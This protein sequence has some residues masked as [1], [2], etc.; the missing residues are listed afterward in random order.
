MSLPFSTDQLELADTVRRF[1][2]ERITTEYLRK[3]A[4]GSS[5]AIL[6]N[7]LC[8]LG[9]LTSFVPE[10]LGGVGFGFR[11]LGLLAIE[12]GRALLP[13][14]ILDMAFSNYLI[15]RAS[16]IDKSELKS[17]SKN[18]LEGLDRVVFA[19]A[20]TVSEAGLTHDKISANLRVLFGGGTAR[21]ALIS[22]ENKSYL[23][24]IKSA[25][26]AS[27]NLVDSTV[28]AASC[29]LSGSPA[30]EVKTSLAVDIVFGIFK[31][32]EIVGAAE[33]AIQMTVDH[34]KTRKQFDV[35][36]GSFQAVQHKLAEA[37]VS[38]SAMKSLSNFAA[39]TV[40]NSP[41]QLVLAGRSAI[42]FAADK[43]PK[44]IE[45]CVQMHGG[46]GFTWEYDLHFY[47]R[48]VKMLSSLLSEM[49]KADDLLAALS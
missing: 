1:L 39:W 29:V 41:D 8:E 12:S 43:G 5:D 10:S 21:F 34:V 13:E 40:E 24:D 9:L 26:L 18:I 33:K 16:N 14:S 49:V 19:P 42:A 3:R 38:L 11:E 47:L 4:P 37:Y 20:I 48:R 35:A 6:F 15:S 27:L 25:K 31:S 23:V 22:L 7:D 17:A 32:L 2:G 30:I 46:T 36:I 45:T 28:G 44:I